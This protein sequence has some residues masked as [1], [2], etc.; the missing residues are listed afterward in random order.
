[1]TISM[2]VAGSLLTWFNPRTMMIVSGLLSALPGLV[3]LLA[4]WRTRFGVPASAVREGYA[5]T[6][7]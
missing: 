7:D 6:A 5:M 3:W 2:L 1:M 4:M